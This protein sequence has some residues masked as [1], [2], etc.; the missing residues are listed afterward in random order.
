MTA[1]N[2]LIRDEVY[3]RINLKKTLA[4]FVLND[5]DIEKTWIPFERLETMNEDGKVYVIG[6]AANDVDALSR[7]NMGLREYRV[8][9]G[10]QVPKVDNQDDSRIDQL[11]ELVE[12]LETV[13]RKE[14]ALDG[15]SFVRLEYMK[16]ENDVPFSFMGMREADMFE[17]YFTA[18]YN[19][20]LT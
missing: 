16:D 3:L 6:L 8:Q 12:Q 17:A 10:L 4:G 18:T 5:W 2:I 11:V 19:T 14:V 13:C 7:T 1:S 9:V 20:I 15:F